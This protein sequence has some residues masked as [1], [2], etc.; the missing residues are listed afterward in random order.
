M[1]TKKTAA[2]RRRE[3]RNKHSVTL[4]KYKNRKSP[5]YPANVNCRRKMKGNDGLMYE[6]LPN[7]NN[8]CTWR[9]VK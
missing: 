5:P 6:S 1:A 4:K 7:V 2:D 8:V 9:K 3:K